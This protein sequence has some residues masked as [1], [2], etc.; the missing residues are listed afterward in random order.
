MVKIIKEEN[1]EYVVNAPRWILYIVYG[2]LAIT[3]A[4]MAIAFSSKT[5]DD[6]IVDKLDYQERGSVN[7]K[8]YYKENNF[9]T[10]PYIGPDK[11]YIAQ[12]IDNIDVDFTYLVNYTENLN[13]TYDYY[14]KARLV[15]YTPGD[16]TDDLWTKE[17][18]MSDVE[19]VE[20]KDTS[21]YNITK[22]IKIN[23]QEFK[24]E[25][26]NY[27]AS[28]MISSNAKLVV[29]LVVNNHSKY[30]YADE[31]DFQANSKLEI[32]LSDSTFQITKS[33]TATGE[34]K[35]I[36][37]KEKNEK[38]VYILIVKVILWVMVVIT[39]GSLISLYRSDTKRVSAYERTLK[40]ILTT[41]DS[42]IVNVKKLPSLS[43]LSV[44]DVTSFE[45]LVDAQNEV[46]LP[47]NFKEDKKKKSAKFVLVRNNLAWVYTL[48]EG[49]LSEEK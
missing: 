3:F 16:E 26:E 34:T 17:Y 32:P 9:Y 22:N 24:E 1:E 39:G 30:K 7:Y 12:Y 5:T 43:N 47:I 6:K 20:F 15:A 29:E 42:I 21:G 33:S 2:I 36:E 38:G 23:F 35:T 18:K 11:T 10:E 37:K 31:I 46:R 13:G 14:V 25:Y 8:V 19:T 40:K 49:D 48:K 41:Y 28:S 27:R 4:A 44:V 45:E